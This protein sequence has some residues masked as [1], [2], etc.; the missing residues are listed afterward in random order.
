MSFN[1]KKILVTGDSFTFGSQVSNNET[2]PSYLERKSKIL[3]FNGGHPG[4]STGQSLRKAIIL[5]KDIEFNYFIWS[6]IYEDFNRDFNTKFIIKENGNLRFNE[7]KKN[8][9]FKEKEKQKLFYHYLKE[10]FFVFYLSDRELFSKILKKKKQP[11][12]YE[13]LIN[14]TT[15]YSEEEL[16]NFLINEFLK[17]KIENKYILIQ[18]TDQSKNTGQ[19]IRDARR[20]QIENKYS[21]ILFDAAYKNGIKILDTKIAFEEMSED[22]KRLLWFDHHTDKG[23]EVVANFILKEINF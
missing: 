10:I 5:S 14:G 3:V 12:Y 4:Y 22:K 21:K 20:E 7:F 17:I 23:N 19:K 9:N 8:K 18:Y 1:K 11:K 6:I 13:A 15:D 16:I 2:W